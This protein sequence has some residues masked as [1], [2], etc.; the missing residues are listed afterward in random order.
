MNS[1]HSRKRARGQ[2]E[3][4][5]KHS[6][7]RNGREYIKQRFVEESC[8]NVSGGLLFEDLKY[9]NKIVPPERADNPVDLIRDFQR[10]D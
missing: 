4:V 1:T 8:W 5:K 9:Y 6:A 10:H 7:K 2:V 3:S